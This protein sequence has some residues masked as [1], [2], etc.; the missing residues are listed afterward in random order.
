M[1]AHPRPIQGI[2]V[3]IERDGREIERLVAGTPERACQMLVVWLAGAGAVHPGDC[4]T[5]E[6]AL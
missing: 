6:E 2:V 3:V 4:I 1:P 5:I